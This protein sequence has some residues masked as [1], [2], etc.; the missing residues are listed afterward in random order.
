MT[1][2]GS[3]YLRVRVTLPTAA[4]NGFQGKSSTL[5]Y[6]FDATQRTATAK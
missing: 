5:Q 3:D 1:A 2:G 6:T 4:G